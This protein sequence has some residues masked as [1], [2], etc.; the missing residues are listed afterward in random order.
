MNLFEL[1]ISLIRSKSVSFDTKLKLF[2][3]AVQSGLN[4]HR[5]IENSKDRGIRKQNHSI[6]VSK[7]AQAK[8]M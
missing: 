7:R 3:N 5:F 8:D 6:S 2:K 1:S 4:T